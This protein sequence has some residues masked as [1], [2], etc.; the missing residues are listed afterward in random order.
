MPTKDPKTFQAIVK[1]EFVAPYPRLDLSKGNMRE[2]WDLI[3][4]QQNTMLTGSGG[5]GKSKMITEYTRLNPNTV[6]LAPTGTAARLIGG[7]TI[8]SF[9]SINPHNINEP[10]KPHM[11]KKIREIGERIEC[12]IIDECGMVRADL[13]DCIDRR[14]QQMTGKPIPFG[15]I[16]L[17]L[18]FDLWQLPPVMKKLDYITKEET[19]EYTV[20]K[21]MYDTVYFFGA[22]VMQR[23]LVN[24]DIKLI[25]LT[26]CFRQ[27]GDLQYAQVLNKIRTG[28]QTQTDLDWLNDQCAFRESRLG[29]PTT[30]C[31][32]K[33]KAAEINELRLSSL[34]SK[35]KT[36]DGTATGTFKD[37]PVPISN[38]L[39]IGASVMV[40][41]N[42]QKKDSN[43]NSRYQNGT[44]GILTKIINDKQVEVVLQ[45]THQKVIFSEHAWEDHSYSL[46]R[47]TESV[48][49][50]VT[51]TYLA[52]PLIVCYAM[53][54]HLTQGST[55]TEVIFDPQFGEWEG[56]EGLIYVALSRVTSV[57][58]LA[59]TRKLRMSDFKANLEVRKFFQGHQLKINKL[60]NL[61]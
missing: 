59:L 53:N 40:K 37:F 34:T 43:G 38:R 28:E 26:H 49:V 39:K 52:L 3:H 42:D 5:V 10:L 24:G 17:I 14:C 11:F 1:E 23:L 19:S 20:F 33:K 45:N 16:K 61:G 22:N 12:I 32:T 36:F 27:G 13:L 47:E 57:R 58:G 4:N 21:Q 2:A 48:E 56:G 15:G 18:S 31:L 55:L 54:A 50:E 51:G 41:A 60:D 6:I 25:E 8:H 9:F 46:N 7:Q 29:N 44:K 30:I 35:G